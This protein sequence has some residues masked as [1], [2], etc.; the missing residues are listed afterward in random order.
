MP[1]A[2]PLPFQ[3]V[4]GAVDPALQPAS[5]VALWADGDL[6]CTGVLVRPGAVLTAAH[7]G[8]ADVV[9]FS[10]GT[11]LGEVG[12]EDAPDTAL[13]ASLRFLDGRARLPP[14]PLADGPP[15][16]GEALVVAGY[17][18]HDGGPAD[19]LLRAGTTTVAQPGCGLAD[20]CVDREPPAELLTAGDTGGCDGDSGGPLLRPSGEDRWEVVGVL[21]RLTRE[22]ADCGQGEVWVR[23]DVIAP[24]IDDAA[25][26]GCAHGGAGGWP[27]AVVASLLHARRARR[28]AR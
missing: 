26:C 20:G 2:S 25:G 22:A 18:R 23:A 8:D 15:A 7:C 3:P 5:V 16:A 1:P 28:R 4:V 17:G 11:V 19:G 6:L 24:W 12:R 21:S 9:T 14:Y 10:D 27:L 13:D